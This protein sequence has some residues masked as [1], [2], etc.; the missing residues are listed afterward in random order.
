MKKHVRHDGTEVS[1]RGMHIRPDGNAF[2]WRCRT[3]TSFGRA[4]R[5]RDAIE[6]WRR[7]LP[8][9]STEAAAHLEERTA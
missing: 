2:V 8:A 7:H 3:C 1:P 5:R 6:D 9:D 4:Y